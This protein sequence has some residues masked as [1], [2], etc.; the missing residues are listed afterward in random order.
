[1]V[2]GPK[3]LDDSNYIF[4]AVS[5][6]TPF[7][8]RC[9]SDFLKKWLLH[10]CTWLD[11]CT[12][13]VHRLWVNLSKCMDHTLNSGETDENMET[14][15]QKRWTTH[16][17]EGKQMKTSK[18]KTWTTYSTD[19]QTNR[20]HEP[21]IQWGNRWKQ[22]NRKQKADKQKTDMRQTDKQTTREHAPHT[23]QWG[24]RWKHENRKQTNR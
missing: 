6:Q 3:P 24:N 12:Q 21:H 16:P 18:Q 5:C 22:T 14:D 15:K 2:P 7:C 19:K 8:Y 4:Y 23:Q 11:L 13:S 20:R 1:M 17:A 10:I 9:S